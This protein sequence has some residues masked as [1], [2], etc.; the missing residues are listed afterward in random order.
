MHVASHRI[1]VLAWLAIVVVA[2]PTSAQNANQARATMDYLSDLVQRAEAGGTNLVLSRSVP[3][4]VTLL[5]IGGIPVVAYR[6]ENNWKY[7]DF[8]ASTFDCSAPGVLRMTF[9]VNPYGTDDVPEFIKSGYVSDVELISSSIGLDTVL[10]DGATILGAVPTLDEANGPS[11]MF[12]ISVEVPSNGK[13]ASSLGPTGNL[14]VILKEGEKYLR[15]GGGANLSGYE[16]DLRP[17]LQHCAMSDPN[18]EPPPPSVAEV[19]NGQPIGLQP[20]SEQ[21]QLALSKYYGLSVGVYSLLL[22]AENAGFEYEDFKLHDCFVA[23]DGLV[24]CQFSGRMLFG[25]KRLAPLTAFLNT[26]ITLTGP[27]WVSV[28]VDGSNWRVTQDYRSCSV[29]TDSI[30]CDWYE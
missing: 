6:K 30:Y 22:G 29:G 21:L 23:K 26:M 16:A 1:I 27:R 19:A 28:Q 11:T 17:L 8:L 20:T 25:D 24:F 2:S 15:L 18:Y 5:S 10:P 9:V 12:R 4:S 13:V 3:V 7:G 14:Q